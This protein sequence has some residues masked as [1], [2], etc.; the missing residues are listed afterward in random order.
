MNEDFVEAQDDDYAAGNWAINASSNYLGGDSRLYFDHRGYSAWKTPPI[1]F[2]IP[3][4]RPGLCLVEPR[5]LQPKFSWIMM[6]AQL[7]VWT[8]WTRLIGSASVTPGKCLEAGDTRDPPVGVSIALTAAA[9]RLNSGP[10]S[11]SD[12]QASVALCP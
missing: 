2:F 4:L 1:T 6:P 3:D 9:S 8:S 7:K 10:V 5:R 11:A 12:R